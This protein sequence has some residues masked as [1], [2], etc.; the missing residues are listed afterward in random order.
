MA[1]VIST[2]DNISK[3]LVEE[4]PELLPIYEMWKT[5]PGLAKEMFFKT[6]F[7]MNNSAAVQER[8]KAKADQRGAYDKNIDAY[9]LATRK[10]L[11]TAGVKLDD[12]TFNE[13]TQ[14]AYDNGFNDD[15]VDSFLSQ[16]QYLLLEFYY[17]KL[18]LRLIYH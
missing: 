18:L 3:A 6:S 14:T 12:A 16:N 15:Q 4:Y 9:R 17:P 1:D 8:L 5:N 10:R 11:T 2:T 7:F 13:V